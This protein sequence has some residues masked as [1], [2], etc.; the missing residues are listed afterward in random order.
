MISAE[1]ALAVETVAQGGVRKVAGMRW[2]QPVAGGAI[3]DGVGFEAV[4]ASIE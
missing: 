4:P 1:P 2:W 3:G